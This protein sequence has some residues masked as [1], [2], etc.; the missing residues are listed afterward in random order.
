MILNNHRT[1]IINDYLAKLH[2]LILESGL[3]LR[4]ERNGCC[5]ARQVGFQEEL[6]TFDHTLN[7]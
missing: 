2:G 7:P 3:I 6:T 4:V 5:S 1:F